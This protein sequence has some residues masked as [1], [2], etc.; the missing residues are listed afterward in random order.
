M[1]ILDNLW[2]Q[3]VKDNPHTQEIYDLFVKN[4]EKPTNDHIALRTLDNKKI[5]IYKLAQPFIDNGYTICD[6]YDFKLKKLK[7]I[8]L[9][10]KDKTQPKIFISQL[11][12]E[13]FSKALQKVLKECVSLI[14]NELLNDPEKLLLSGTTWD[15]N[16]TTYK[17]LLNESEYAAWFYAF[18][19]RANHF[20]VFINDLKN[21]DE[22][23]QVN[24]F[25]KKNGFKL[26]SSGGEIKG[27][28]AD[29]LEQS[30][31]MSG[32]TKVNFGNEYE[33]I[34]CCYYEFAKRYPDKNNNLY[35]GFVAKSADK[36][37][38]S[39]NQKV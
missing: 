14:P 12:I 25:L 30:S 39:T 28:K 17:E 18:G 35:Q 3:Y 6:N 16:F 19:F 15:I 34:P 8:H 24:D 1:D 32:L 26:N 4:G 27:S 13:Y 38:E 20:T 2:K 11:L 7:A 10:H 29:L 22:V 23:S 33:E 5:D 37:F 36:I 31:T 21:F 9:E